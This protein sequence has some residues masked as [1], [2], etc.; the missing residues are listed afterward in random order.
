M[1]FFTQA[2]QTYGPAATDPS[3]AF[4]AKFNEGLQQGNTLAND[5]LLAKGQYDDARTNALNY[6]NDASYD[7]ANTIQ[8]NDIQRTLAQH[9]YIGRAAQSLANVPEAMRSLVYQTNIKPQLDQLGV[10]ANLSASPDLSNAGLNALVSNSQSVKDQW[11]R[12]EKLAELSKPLA[13]SAGQTAV[14]AGYDPL[15]MQPTGHNTVAGSGPNE[16]S[17][18]TTTNTNGSST[19]H[20]FNKYGVVPTGTGQ[21]TGGSSG[22]PASTG[23]SA[24]ANMSASGAAGG[25][26]NAWAFTLKHEG[27]YNAH[28]GNGAPVNFGINQKANPDIDVKSL[29]PQAAA[30]LAHDRY[31]VPSGAAN[32]PA[33]MQTP[34]FDAY[35]MNPRAAQAA[36]SRSGNNPQAFVQSFGN[37]LQSTGNAGKYGKVWARR[38]S[39]LTNVSGQSSANNGSPA[40]TVDAS[41]QDN[42]NSVFGASIGGSD[43][44]AYTQHTSDGHDGFTKGQT[45]VVDAKGK[46]EVAANPQNIWNP[47]TVQLAVAR[48][49]TNPRAVIDYG[50]G[51]DAAT[52]RANVQNALAGN[53]AQSGQTGADVETQ[54]VNFD[55]GSHT[56]QAQT[57]KVAGLQQSVSNVKQDTK[58]WVDAGD[59][60]AHQLGIPF[61]DEHTQA[62]MRASGDSRIVRLDTLAQ[63]LVGEVSK[64]QEGSINAAS[65]AHVGTMKAQSGVFANESNPQQRRAIADTIIQEGDRAVQSAQTALTQSYGAVTTAPTHGGVPVGRGAPQQSQGNASAIAA[66]HRAIAA[67]A[68]PQAVRQRLQ[69]LGIT[70]SGQ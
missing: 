68:N 63:R 20:P 38:E 37:W 53:V 4:L 32:L 1:D 36:L 40:A 24:P 5:R 67:G 21:G 64:M 39:D 8:S 56:I 7:H 9:E 35:Y 22:A 16:V 70:P 13:L 26:D 41:T 15:T 43:A 49:R 29:T 10:P 3:G 18:V 28:D 46:P 11:A 55:A 61:L 58:A 14:S 12:Q 25:F 27:G 57:N 6:G 45:I 34:Y 31:W 30:Q 54:G 65:G 51:D 19:A 69:S 62:A 17:T 44:P 2:A 66:A 42:G 47:D 23:N 48:L 52:N 60:L 50:R 59:A 33:N